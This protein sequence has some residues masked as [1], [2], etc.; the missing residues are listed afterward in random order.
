MKFRVSLYFTSGYTETIILDEEGISVLQD[1][2]W[3]DWHDHFMIN[4][5][6]YVNFDQVTHVKV[7]EEIE[8]F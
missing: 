3:H 2:L 8:D 4:D 5:D 1:K 7:E 6:L